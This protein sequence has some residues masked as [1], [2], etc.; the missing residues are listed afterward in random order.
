MNVAEFESQRDRD[1]V[2]DGSP[3][4][5]SKHAVILEQFEECMRPSEL[6]F[7][8]LQLC[9]RV[10]NLPYNLRNDTWCRC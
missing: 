5:V 3:W 6:K 1:M 8:K 2:L 7:D 10:I 4:H 9:A